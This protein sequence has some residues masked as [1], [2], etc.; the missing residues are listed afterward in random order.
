MIEKLHIDQLSGEYRITVLPA[1]KILVDSGL[2][3]LVARANTNHLVDNRMD[4]ESE[5]E[6]VN[7][8]RKVRQ[9]NRILLGLEESAR[10]LTKGIENA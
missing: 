8:V 7:E 3:S 9:A 2:L 6:I 1:L 4:C 5:E 10:E